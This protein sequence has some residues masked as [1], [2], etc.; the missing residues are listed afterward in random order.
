MIIE[1]I[2]LYNYFNKKRINGAAGYLKSYIIEKSAFAKDRIRPAILIVAGGGYSHLS[3]REMEPVAIKYIESGF[4]CF[5]LEYSTT[6]IYYPTQLIEAAM[7]MLYIKSKAEQYNIDKSLV[8]ALGFSAGAHL[9]GM[10]ATLTDSDIIEKQLNQNS[11]LVRPDA[12]ILGYPVVSATRQPHVSSLKN[13]S[14]GDIAIYNKLSVENNI[15]KNSSPAFIWG[16]LDDPIVHSDNGFVLAA[17]YKKAGVPFEYH[18]FESCNGTHGLSIC[19]E[20]TLYINET[21]KPWVQLSKTWLKNRGFVI[22]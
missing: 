15:D 18:L 8:A 17:A 12:V 1:K 2:D 6:P 11:S 21:V 13:I 16:C 4:N 20:E 22:K 3:E 5:T 19:E 10:L 7:A 9:C 14:G